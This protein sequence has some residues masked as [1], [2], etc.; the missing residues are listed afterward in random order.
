LIEAY[1]KGISI[2][3]EKVKHNIN[4]SLLDSIKQ[5][6]PKEN[7]KVYFSTILEHPTLNAT[8]FEQVTI[9]NCSVYE[10]IEV[11]IAD[12]KDKIYIE[13]KSKLI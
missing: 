8:M 3:F 10:K 12:E 11:G 5:L 13:S 9:I 6:E 1:E 4:Q 7:F 2:L